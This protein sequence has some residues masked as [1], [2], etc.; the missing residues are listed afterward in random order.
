MVS[1]RRVFA[2]HAARRARA[3]A[4][5]APGI[6]F[7]DHRDYAPGDDF[8]YLD[9]NLYGR[10]DRL[11]LRLFEEEEDLHIYLLVDASA[12][13]AFGSPP[14]LHHALQVGAALAYVG[15]ANL[16][17]VARDRRSATRR[18]AGVMPPARGKAAILPILRLLDGVDA[19]GER[20][21]RRRCA[22]SWRRGGGGGAGWRSSSPTSTT[23]RATGPRWICCATTGWRSSPS[24]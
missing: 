23:R 16:D 14:K 22:R 19:A 3:R 10:L 17:R 6:E 24:R 4:R 5:S 18:R 1:R 15:L 13:M 2:G 9:W 12:S 21:W 8:R 11:L 20:R 7:A